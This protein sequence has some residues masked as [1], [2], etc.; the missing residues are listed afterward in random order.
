MEQSVI[1]GGE[2]LEAPSIE[3]RHQIEVTS[4]FYV[5]IS[6]RYSF[7][8]WQSYGRE[9]DLHTLAGLEMGLMG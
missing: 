1:K 3:K 8:D 2:K 9:A 5:F 4:F 7:S 6:T